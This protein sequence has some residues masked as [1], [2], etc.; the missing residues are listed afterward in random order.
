MTM[1]PRRRV[2]TLLT[3][4]AAVA[5]VWVARDPGGSAPAGDAI[6]SAGATAVDPTTVAEFCAAFESLSK[7]VAD[8][9]PQNVLA[10]AAATLDEV[11]SAASTVQDVAA[12][13]PLP[14]AVTP[15]LDY[16]TDLFLTLP[17]GTPPSEVALTDDDATVT[18]SYQVDLLVTFLTETC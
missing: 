16:I 7:A 5:T 15:G 14:P 8:S 6:T 10:P 13:A 4:A 12:R 18:E 1:H 17:D 11:R 9:A 2:I 3:A